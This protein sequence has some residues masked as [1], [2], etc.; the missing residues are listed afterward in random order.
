M[1]LRILHSADWHLDSP[2]SSLPPQAREGLRQA[3]RKLPGL[4]GQLLR[5]EECDLALLAGDLFDGT[6]SPNIPSCN[7][8]MAIWQAAK[9]SFC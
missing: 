6:P 8:T 2:F 5:Q 3:Q 9:T 4:V 1:G 7:V